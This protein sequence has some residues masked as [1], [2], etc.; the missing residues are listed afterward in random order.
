MT[1]FRDDIE[2]SARLWRRIFSGFGILGAVLL[3]AFGREVVR[4]TTLHAADAEEPMLVLAAAVLPFA[5]MSLYMQTEVVVA[6]VLGLAA[7]L[8][9][10]VAHFAGFAGSSAFSQPAR[11]SPLPLLP[12]FALFFCG[13]CHYVVASN[14]DLRAHLRR[15]DDSRYSFKQA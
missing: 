9:F 10:Y 14:A 15:L 3:A 6:F 7:P 13:A 12:L 5:L 2:A 8:S 11:Q 1:R 4:V